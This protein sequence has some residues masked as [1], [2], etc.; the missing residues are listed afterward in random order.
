M[1][2]VKNTNEEI[3]RILKQIERKFNKIIKMLKVKV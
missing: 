3:V 1:K 2:E